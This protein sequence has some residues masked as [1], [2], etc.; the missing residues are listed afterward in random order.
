MRSS[1]RAMSR[2]LR[3]ALS[4]LV[5]FSAAAV[6][7]RTRNVRGQVDWQDLAVSHI[8]FK[9]SNALAANDKVDRPKFEAREAAEAVLRMIKRGAKFEDMAYAH[10][11]CRSRVRAGF[12]GFVPPPRGVPLNSR[13]FRGIPDGSVVIARALRHPAAELK[14]GALSE[15]VE[16]PF[17][18][19][20]IR[21]EPAARAAFEIKKLEMQRDAYPERVHLAHILFSYSGAHRWATPTRYTFSKLGV[22]SRAEARVTADRTLALLRSGADFASLAKERSDCL[23]REEGGYLSSFRPGMPPV[24]PSFAQVAFT[25]KPGEMSCVVE[26]PHGFHII[27]R[28]K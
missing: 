28:L 15:I 16:T 20:I 7:C 3:L 11:D 25:L 19:H 13:G 5:L 14:E 2:G 18:Y 22:R 6:A 10:S 21:R 9:H 26:T 17:G 23:S 8:L 4:T 1:K 27:K 24:D 12:L